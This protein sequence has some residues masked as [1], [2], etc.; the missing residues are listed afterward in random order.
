MLRADDSETG[1]GSGINWGIRPYGYPRNPNQAYIPYNSRDKVADFFSDR[2]KP[3]DKNCPMFRV[4]TKDYGSFHMR[5]VQGGN[6]ALQSVESNAI[7]GEWIRKRIG[8]P[9]GGFITRKMLDLYG[10]TYVTFRK[11]E[12]GIYL[13]DF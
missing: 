8:V 9:S 11:Y 10:R 7:I 12:N 5:V 4:I 2:L 6:K 3:E 1:Y 13:L